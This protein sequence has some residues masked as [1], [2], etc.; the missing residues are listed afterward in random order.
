[1]NAAVMTKDIAQSIK[2]CED[3]RGIQFGVTNQANC[4]MA[5]SPVARRVKSVMVAAALMLSVTAAP[6]AYAVMT[7]QD[8][9]EHVMQAERDYSDAHMA[10]RLA[11][12]EKGAG[13]MG[14]AE[15]KALQDA[16]AARAK[17]YSDQRAAKYAEQADIDRVLQD[18]AAHAVQTNGITHGTYQTKSWIGHEQLPLT[19]GTA[20]TS[21]T[22]P[23]TTTKSYTSG[24]PT[25]TTGKGISISSNPTQTTGDSL[26]QS[27]VMGS[28]PT[29][30]GQSAGT[31]SADSSTNSSLSST[32][33]TTSSIQSNH[34]ATGSTTGD[35][36]VTAINEEKA[37]SDA[38]FANGIAMT[39]SNIQRTEQQAVAKADAMSNAIDHPVTASKD[40]GDK[41][42][43]S[44]IQRTEAQAV[45]LADAHQA[46]QDRHQFDSLSQT[47]I[48][49]DHTA[50]ADVTVTDASI[51]STSASDNSTM[52]VS[53]NS[54]PS[55]TKV[56]ATI[57]GTLVSITAGELA[58]IKPETDVQKPY[59][60]ALFG[61][62]HRVSN[63]GGRSNDGEGSHGG[64]GNGGENAQASHSAGNFSTEHDHIGGGR[65]GGGFHY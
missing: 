48:H 58:T 7:V 19:A 34:T 56:N 3:K 51:T 65:S 15:E 13:I 37:A 20:H 25:G 12:Y 28:N 44:N 64:T 63:G 59:N 61:P 32:T 26:S 8:A 4:E 41:L 52:N 1:M 60:S 49:A 43:Q 2:A 33:A 31:L 62:T 40:Y 36:A 21:S 30:A 35:N 39:Q 9:H 46:D 53:V 23:L 14:S 24:H 42:T 27:Q 22:G 38:A 10:Y 54:L 50:P 29:S 16:G 47:T 5:L 11:A 18:R 57:N 55:E 6:S 45:A 17:A